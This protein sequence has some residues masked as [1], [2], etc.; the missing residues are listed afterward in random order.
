MHPVFFARGATPA[1]PITFVT[2][3]SWAEQRE[4]LEA[5]ARA[6]CEAAGFEPKAG[7]HL[8][9]PGADGAFAGVLFG[10]ESRRRTR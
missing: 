5:R 1:V 3:A 7:R 8:L 6:Y 4:A 9:L 2:P 10:L